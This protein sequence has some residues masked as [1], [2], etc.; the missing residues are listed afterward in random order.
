LI[1]ALAPG[2]TA[3]IPV[4]ERLLDP[5][6][7]TDVHTVTFG[8]DGDVRFAQQGDDRVV[9]DA[10]GERIELEVAFRQ[11]HLR[12][13]L[14]AAVA[15]ALAV[16]VTPSGRVDLKLSAGRGER[17]AVD[18]GIMVLDGCYNANPMSM[19]A[20]L[21]DLAATAERV[22]ASR[23]VAVLGDMLE[24]GP[25]ARRY[26]EQL[27]ELADDAGV[28]V[29]VTVG[30]LAAAITDRFHGEAR[31]LADAGQAADLVPRLLREG[32]L[33]LVKGSLGVGLRQV[34]GALGIR[35]HA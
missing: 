25:E 35:A 22:H 33:V 18:G 2:G 10:A 11:A 27:G 34:C 31:S 9:I 23:R 21:T 5:W 7:R 15:A 3:V 13:N 20:A 6:L 24:L 16:G 32:D 12:G 4:G 26:H 1:G 29:L 28:D 30:P 19:R 14:L 8:A 17:V